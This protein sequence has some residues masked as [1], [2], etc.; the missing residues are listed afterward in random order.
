MRGRQPTLGEVIDTEV[1]DRLEQVVAARAAAC[2]RARRAS[3]RR[4]STDLLSTSTDDRPET[5]A[6]ASTLNPPRNTDSCARSSCSSAVEELVR[7]VDGVPQRSLTCRS[8]SAR[9]ETRRRN[10]SSRRRLISPID[11]V[12]ARAAASSMASGTPSRSR[13]ISTI[14]A[15]VSGSS[16]TRAPHSFARWTNSSIAGATPVPSPVLSSGSGG[17]TWTDSPVEAE[18]FATR[19]QQRHG[20]AV[21]VESGGH[22]RRRTGARAHSCRAP[23]G[24]RRRGTPIRHCQGATCRAADGRPTSRPARRRSSHPW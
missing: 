13:Q 9:V 6:A 21:P 11:M 8:V 23:P 24:H 16:S 3:G 10:R 14:A 2:G 12:R 22:V 19:H 15:W 7:P 5:A 18:R 4:A 20:W 1:S 17:T